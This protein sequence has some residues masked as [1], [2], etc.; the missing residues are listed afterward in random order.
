MSAN[1]TQKTARTAHPR[2]RR[3]QS[4]HG[5]SFGMACLYVLIAASLV[6]AWFSPIKHM[7]SGKL[8]P[9]LDKGP[10]DSYAFVALAYGDA[11]Q[12]LDKALF[13]RHIETLSANGCVPLTLADVSALINEGLPVPRKSVLITV[14]SE[15]KQTVAA[16]KNAIRKQRWDAVLFVSTKPVTERTGRAL[17]WNQVRALA[18]T[19]EWE[20]GARSHAGAELVRDANGRDR[21]YLACRLARDGD[22]QAESLTDLRTRIHDD[23]RVCAELFGDRIGRVPRAYA[24][25]FG[26]FGQTS[27][28]PEPIVDANVQAAD[29]T[30]EMAFTS[31]GL[32]LNTLF[33]DPHRI[34]RL[35]VP[36][37]WTGRDVLNAVTAAFET[38]DRVED[39]DLARRQPGWTVD[40]GVAAR[41]GD[42][43]IVGAAPDATVGRVWLG[44]SDLRTDFGATLRLRLDKGRASILARANPDLST[45]VELAITPDGDVTLTQKPSPNLPPLRLAASQTVIG[46]QREHR[47]DIYVRGQNF[48]ATIDGARLFPDRIRLSGD[49]VPGLLG[50]AVES[51]LVG[52]ARVRV[53]AALMESRRSALA[54]WDL[55]SDYDSYVI[56]WLHRNASRLTDISPPWAHLLTT[57]AAGA[58]HRDNAAVFRTLAQIHGLRL[59]PKADI[60]DADSMAQWAP[61][62]LAERVDELDCDGFF[63]NFADFAALQAADLERWLQQSSR[64]LSR[65]GKP[66][67]VRLPP[68]M[69]RLAAVNT[70]LAVIPSVEIVTGVGVQ[71]PAVGVAVT[72]ITEETVPAPTREQHRS[73]PIA[74]AIEDEP[75]DDS[76]ASK[77]LRIRRLRE[78]AESEFL[79]GS[80][81]KAIAAFSEWH[82]LDPGATRP[83]SRI[84]DALVNLGYHAEAIDFYG[85]SLAV[86]PGQ[87][88]MAVRQA[89]LLTSV[90]R[91]EEAKTLLNAY[92]RLFPNNTQVMFA[93]AEWL[94]KQNRM[95]EAKTRVQRILGLDPDNFDATLFMLRLSGLPEDRGSAMEKLLALADVPEKH[96]QVVNAIW[97]YDLLTLQDS[98]ILVQLLERISTAS[99]DAR[100]RNI[101]AKLRPRTDIVREDFAA[102]LSENWFVDGAAQSATNTLLTLTA[103][104]TR[105]EFAVRLLRSERWRDSFVEADVREA[106]GGFW[107]HARR[108]R[109]H[110]VRFGFDPEADRI[111]I[112]AWKG[113]NNDVVLSQFVPWE[114][115][116]VSGRF[117]LEIRGNGIVAM[118]DGKQVFD[119]VLPLPEDFGLGWVSMAAHAPERGKAKLVLAALKAGPLPIRLAMLPSA[120]STE[121]VDAELSRMRNM[122]D[123]V[124]DFSPD[125]FTVDTNGNW[126]SQLRPEE[127]FFKLFA[128]YYRVRF[129]P[130]V[131]AQRADR[132][133]AED[134]LTVTRTHGLDGLVLRFEEMPGEDWFN[135][136]DTALL[137]PG[138]DLIALAPSGEKNKLI[139]RRI[140]ASKTVFHSAAESLVTEIDVAD[141]EAL[142]ALGA[143]VPAV[144][145]FNRE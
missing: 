12:P 23:Y 59:V 63:A 76:A 37:N 48:D 79:G 46:S 33:T 19:R 60:A 142:R 54:S 67:L 22:T 58:E 66:L 51:G 92:A 9:P 65:T 131:R 55:E 116:T 110:L 129:V 71:L 77:N 78:R 91:T 68:M 80:Y 126:K 3:R 64:M 16:A 107:L 72:P 30:F 57:G 104:P 27:K 103:N 112:Q 122:L 105:Q 43:I 62:R 99:K 49:P 89:R 95:A 35:R 11:E 119:V 130:T 125:W 47:I 118:L 101:I 75:E 114:H 8:W 136:M 140:A 82:N 88:D 134:I 127:D 87:I 100:V 84:G 5:F 69:E 38:R 1:T 124:T 121:N 93:Q 14:D 20:V 106:V 143:D 90:N 36:S 97:Q 56:D 24:Y 115:T 81:E 117:R 139:L 73:L 17:S 102:G 85:Q 128:R 98:H 45:Y 70:L 133:A 74:F 138:L 53:G 123:S 113:Q 13:S 137:D 29:A 50:V 15:R 96:Y 109:D 120:P 7:V 135:R 108:S 83:L 86:D 31:G 25:P 40:R 28:Q 10:R 18:N 41:E 144:M 21:H 132:I 2:S 44:G 141:T 39:S 111:F 94:Y 4:R 6:V 145:W 61:S 32:G 34:N 42:E 52:A 26:E